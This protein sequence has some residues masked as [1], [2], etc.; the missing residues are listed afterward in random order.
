MTKEDV[1][2]AFDD[3]LR[4]PEVEKSGNI[5]SDELK[6]RAARF[7]VHDRQGLVEAVRQWLE[8]RDEVL[9]IQAA[10][11]IREFRLSELRDSIKRI[12]EEVAAGGFMRPSSIWIFDKAIASLE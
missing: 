6:R 4:L 11:L 9:A 1:L 8:S 12:R 5:L 2:A 10:V 3:A 7:A